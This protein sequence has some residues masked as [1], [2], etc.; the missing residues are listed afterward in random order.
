MHKLPPIQFDFRRF[1]SQYACQFSTHPKLRAG[2]QAVERRWQNLARDILADEL[3]SGSDAQ[4]ARADYQFRMHEGV[5]GHQNLD[6]LRTKFEG[7]D[8]LDLM[9]NIGQTVYPEMKWVVLEGD[10]ENMAL[11]NEERT[12]VL[13]IKHFDQLSGGASLAFHEDP[14]Y[15]PTSADLL[16]AADTETK[17]AAQAESVVALMRRHLETLDKNGDV[18]KFPDKNNT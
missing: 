18:L 6:W 17:R 8:L 12:L 10:G 2:F 4:R 3:E 7:C 5:L 1:W 11:V 15:N 9:E 16:A 14:E 13:D